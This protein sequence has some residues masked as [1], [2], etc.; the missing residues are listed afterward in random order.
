MGLF[1]GVQ[2]SLFRKGNTI[3]RSLGINVIGY[4]APALSLLWLFSLSL[5]HVARADLLVA[6][7]FLIISA[8]ALVNLGVQARLKRGRLWSLLHSLWPQ[9]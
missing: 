8:N 9:H 6:G 3:N 2:D 5:T 1:Y 7:C 4:M